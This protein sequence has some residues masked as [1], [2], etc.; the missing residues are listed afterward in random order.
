MLPTQGVSGLLCCKNH[1]LRCK[2]CFLRSTAAYTGTLILQGGKLLLDIEVLLTE[3]VRH[4]WTLD[5]KPRPRMGTFC[6]LQKGPGAQKFLE[7]NKTVTV[8]NVCICHILTEK[9]P[10]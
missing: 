9:Y 2:G 8:K 7:T 1:P 4:L 5:G 10:L 3:K 6:G